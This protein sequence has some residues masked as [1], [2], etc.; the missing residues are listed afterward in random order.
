MDLDKVIKSDEEALLLLSNLGFLMRDWPLIKRLGGPKKILHCELLSSLIEKEHIDLSLF[1]EHFDEFLATDGFILSHIKSHSRLFKCTKAPLA[2][3]GRFDQRLLDE[4]KAVAIVGSRNASI[5][6]RNT[7]KKLASFLA[8]K[9]FLIVSGGA[10]G[11][12]LCAHE[13][14]IEAGGK[15][16]AISGVAIDLRSLDKT[17]MFFRQHQNTAILYPFGPFVPQGKFMFVERNRFVASTSDAVVVVEGQKG[18]GTLHTANFAKKLNVPLFAIPGALDNPKAFAPNSLL[19]AGD[20]KALVD[21]DLFVAR[22]AKEKKARKV[23]C[24]SV[25]KNLVEPLPK[26]LQVLKDHENSLSFDEL[27]KITGKSFMELQKE[28]FEFELLGQVTKRG[29]QFVLTAG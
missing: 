12:D 29:A 13:G 22:V 9:N 16:L 25:E 11:I 24:L 28:L 20:A 17:A 4:P 27:L 2:L 8:E 3:L 5:L 14:A 7:A 23:K 10:M 1:R 6:G 26:L 15:T 18:S 19:D 21:Y